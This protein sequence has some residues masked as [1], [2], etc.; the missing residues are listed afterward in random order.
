MMNG[1]PTANGPSAPRHG[2]SAE[3][4]PARTRPIRRTFHVGGLAFGLTFASVGCSV[5]NEDML[6]FLREHEHEVSA[7]EYRVG[8]PDSIG[9]SS[10]RI[11]EIDGVDQQVHPDGKVNLRLLGDVKIVG[12]TAKE[13]AA[14]LEVLLSRYYVDP[15]VSVRV[16]GFHSK[17][18]Y[19][20][21]QVGAQG[22]H[23]Y[24]GR[25][26]LLDA[27]LRA[28]VNYTSWTS[29]VSVVRPSHGETAVRTIMV[30]ID[31][32]VKRG[33][34][35]KNILLEP[36]DIVNIPPT[37]MAW[38]GQRAQQL[39]QPVAPVAQVYLTPARVRDL[40]DAYDDDGNGSYQS[41]GY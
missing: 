37:P 31:E 22:P 9:I 17:K 5:K 12:M 8:I 32:M 35:S 4:A 29:R 33:D 39:V 3:A 11:L 38:L 23:P 28:G 1:K 7:I 10:P 14:K 6:H 15:K 26:T 36:D 2:A 16:T 40:E 41:G 20:Y 34:W 30:N 24:T 19:V 25:D 18:Y 27:V 13:I 21:G